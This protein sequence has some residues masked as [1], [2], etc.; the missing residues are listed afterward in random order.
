M[1]IESMSIFLIVM[2]VFVLEIWYCKSG[3]IFFFNWEILYC[4]VYSS[5]LEVRLFK[6]GCD[7]DGMLVGRV[8]IKGYLFKILMFKVI[9][10]YIILC[11]E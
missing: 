1:R 6:Y 2:K 11:K 8:L 5:F 10:F 7:C 3:G 9:F 4:C